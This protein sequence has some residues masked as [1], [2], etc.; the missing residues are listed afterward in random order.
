MQI[1]S[2]TTPN[3]ID[4][5]ALTESISKLQNILLTAANIPDVDGTTVNTIGDL[6]QLASPS[7]S[8]SLDTLLKALGDEVRRQTCRDGVNSL[9]MKA[10]EQK[11][12]NQKELQEI[13]ERLSDMKKKGVLDGFL[14]A[15]KIIGLIV[16][17]VA[18][19]A[20]VVAGALTANPLLIAAGVAGAV[21]TVD[22]IVS[23]ASDGKYSIAAGFTELGKAMGMDDDAAQWFGFGMNMAIMVVTI[24]VSLGAG[25]A[26][27]ASSMANISSQGINSAA[28]IVSTTA[29]VTNIASG[30]NQ[31]ATGATTIAGAVVDYNI[32]KSQ[33]RSKELQAIL[34]RLRQ[35]IETEKALVE[36][37]ME[38]A[39]NLL[40][41]VREIVE[42]C[43]STQSVILSANPGMA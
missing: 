11:E 15:F 4:F 20:S 29:Q 22:S 39:N 36:A 41:D 37:E 32:G 25:F 8:L 40:A 13:A 34:E 19:A 21:M 23:M 28:K 3:T 38:R 35:S 16:G 17:A 1:Q 14:K 31:V 43:V 42:N 18:S 26:S 12:I 6:P 10:E 30:V 24:G 33:A 9:E 5:Q 7:G 2:T 27:S